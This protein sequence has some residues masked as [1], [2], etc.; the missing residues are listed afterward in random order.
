[1]H[2]ELIAKIASEPLSSLVE[3][4]PSSGWRHEHT[5]KCWRAGPS[6]LTQVATTRIRLARS[7]DPCCQG[8][9][10]THPC[11]SWKDLPG[12]L[13][14]LAAVRQQCGRIYELAKQ[15]LNCFLGETAP[16]HS[17]LHMGVHVRGARCLRC[18]LCLPQGFRNG[19]C[20]SCGSTPVM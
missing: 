1:M 14:Q 9:R 18:I 12:D 8:C 20:K 4:P 19:F 15:V 11:G 5:L 13:L 10:W 17:A 6:F 3:A 7:W 2:V 16:L